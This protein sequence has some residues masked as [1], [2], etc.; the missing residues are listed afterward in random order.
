ME[1]VD[2]LDV[3]RKAELL[4]GC[5]EQIGASNIQVKQVPGYICQ[6]L[7]KT[8]SKY[9]TS[10]RYDS[11]TMSASQLFLRPGGVEFRP[12]WIKMLKAVSRNRN[13]RSMRRAIKEPA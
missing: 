10:V 8:K 6:E 2:Q 7:R 3:A 1:G 12:S 13:M 11:P 4:F 9:L 5:P